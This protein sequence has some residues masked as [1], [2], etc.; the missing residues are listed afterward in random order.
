MRQFLMRGRSMRVMI[1]MVCASMALGAAA[2]EK[3]QSNTGSTPAT[4]GGSA[5]GGG[6]GKPA[7]SDSAPLQAMNGFIEAMADADFAGALAFVDPSCELHEKM[8]ETVANLEKL[9]GSGDAKAAQAI[10]V[11]RSMFSAPY[12]QAEASVI[13]EEAGRAMLELRR[14]GDAPMQVPV[15]E[16][17]GG[18]WRISTDTRLFAP[19]QGVGGGSK[20]PANPPAEPPADGGDDEG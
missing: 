3:K 19:V 14:K 16:G 15:I 5:S 17:E 7:A 10:E 6:A 11:T 12:K 13:S 18:Q 4:S 20:P 1:A 8:S 9:A 2:C